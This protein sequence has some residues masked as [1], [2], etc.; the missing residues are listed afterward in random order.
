MGLER[1]W[2]NQEEKGV[3]S[4][5]ISLVLSTMMLAL[6]NQGVQVEIGVS[7]ILHE[8]QNSHLECMGAK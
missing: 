4:Q 5:K 7:Y 3:G 2:L 1:R 8:A 6:Q